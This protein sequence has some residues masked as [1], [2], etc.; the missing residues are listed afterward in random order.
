MK[1]RIFLEQKGFDIP[2]SRRTKTKSKYSTPSKGEFCMK[3]VRDDENEQTPVSV[4]KSAKRK[5]VV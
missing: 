5:K 3:R 2:A 1:K 4:S